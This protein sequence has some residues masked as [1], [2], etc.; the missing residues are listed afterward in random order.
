VTSKG[1][2]VSNVSGRT[3]KG[4]Y[5][6]Y[7][8]PTTTITTVPYTVPTTPVTTTV[9]KPITS[10]YETSS[11]TIKYSLLPT[12]SGYKEVKTHSETTSDGG[13]ETCFETVTSE[14]GHTSYIE[15]S[16]TYTTADGGKRTYVDKETSHGGK[17]RL[18]Y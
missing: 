1:A 11:G 15:K 6:T 4:G 12:S 2:T 14:G 10:S 18:T 3:S 17:S 9:T 8:K 5:T 13:H 16:S 7:T